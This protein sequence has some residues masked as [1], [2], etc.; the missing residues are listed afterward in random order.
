[1]IVDEF[2][3]AAHARAAL[4]GRMH[5]AIE[6]K[7]KVKV[8]RESKTLATITFQNYF[9]LYQ[10][11]RHDRHGLTEENEFREFYKLDV[12]EIRTNKPMSAATS[13]SVYRTQNGKIKSVIELIKEAYEKRGRSGGTAPSNIRDFFRVL[14]KNGIPH[15]VLN[16][17]FHREEPR[18]SPGRKL[19]PS[20]SRPTWRAAATDYH[21]GG[22]A[23]YMA[24]SR[25]KTGL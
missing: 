17:K 15:Q 23:E 24:K 25:C 9:R 22:N 3:R 5:Q 1:M 21:A 6:A 12:I 11:F 16:A 8:Q 14:K 4:F 18:S 19:A 2:T 10:S 13:D 7:E 20:P